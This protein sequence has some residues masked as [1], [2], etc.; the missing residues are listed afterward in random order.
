VTWHIDFKVLYAATGS[1]WAAVAVIAYEGTYSYLHRI[2]CRDRKSSGCGE[3]GFSC[4]DM[5][6]YVTPESRFAFKSNQI[7]LK[8]QCQTGL[9]GRTACTNRSPKHNQRRNEA[10]Q[11][12]QTK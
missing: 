1:R 4:H 5:T 3:A 9:Q 10:T 6:I 12:T 7:Y 11:N 8:T 2:S